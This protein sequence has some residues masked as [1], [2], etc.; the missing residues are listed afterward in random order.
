MSEGFQLAFGTG[1]WRRAHWIDRPSVVMQFRHGNGDAY[2]VRE[3]LQ[4]DLG[5]WEWTAARTITRA[6]YE[7]NVCSES[8]CRWAR[9]KR[10]HLGHGATRRGPHARWLRTYQVPFRD[11]PCP[12]AG[13]RLW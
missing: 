13:R 3:Y 7:R 10:V 9:P 5:R 2:Q 1:A 4:N 8:M 6:E 12:T 11:G